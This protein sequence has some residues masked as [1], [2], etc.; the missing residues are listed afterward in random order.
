M[1]ELLAGFDPDATK[2]DTICPNCLTVLSSSMYYLNKN[3][4]KVELK[5]FTLLKPFVL[6]NKVDELNYANGYIVYI[7]NGYNIEE[8]RDNLQRMKNNS[9][10]TVYHLLLK[11][12]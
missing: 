11:I 7:D 12:L 9:L 1:E 6:M 3:S 10:T 2:K 5:R 8:C 4:K